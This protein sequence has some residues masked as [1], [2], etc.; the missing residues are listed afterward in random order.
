MGRDLTLPYFYIKRLRMDKYNNVINLITDFA[1]NYNIFFDTDCMTMYKFF[2]KAYSYKFHNDDFS[3]TLFRTA[4]LR[5]PDKISSRQKS[6]CYNFSDYL[7][8]EKMTGQDIYY[9]SIRFS[10]F[11]NYFVEFTN[12]H[13]FLYSGADPKKVYVHF[14]NWYNQKVDFVNMYYSYPIIEEII[15]FIKME[16]KKPVAGKIL[17]TDYDNK[18]DSIHVKDTKELEFVLAE[19]K[20]KKKIYYKLKNN[21]LNLKHLFTEYFPQELCD[22]YN[23]DH[24]YVK[25]GD[26]QKDELDNDIYIF[27]HYPVNIE[28]SFHVNWKYVLIKQLKAPSKINKLIRKTKQEINNFL[29][30]KFTFKH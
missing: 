24:L 16:P 9:K 2:K 10:E 11:Y 20:S 3:Y 14:L 12:Q 5:I 8:M 21:K 30:I 13:N 1:S 27:S 19:K 22:F 4:Y 15:F 7:K 28:N 18:T 26:P 23:W 29:N 25:Y 17:F 6:E